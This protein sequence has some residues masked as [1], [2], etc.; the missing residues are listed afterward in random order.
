MSIYDGSVDQQVTGTEG[1]RMLSTPTSDNSYND[2]LSNLWTQGISTGADATNGEA[3]VKIYDGS[4]FNAV[5]DLTST[6]TPG[7]G[8]ITYVFDDDDN[9]GISDGF[10]KTI[11]VTGTENTGSITPLLNSGSDAWSL[12]G[13]P[14]AF[15]IDWD[16]VSKNDLTETLYVYDHS[17]TSYLTWNGSSGSLTGGVIASMQGFWV[18]NLDVD[19]AP[20]PNLTFEESDQ[21]SEGIFYKEDASNI[22]IELNAALNDLNSQTFL[23]FTESGELAKDN[24]DGLKLSPLDFKNYLSIATV[25]EDTKLDINNLP[26]DFEGEIK[27]PVSIQAFHADKESNEWISKKGEIFL[28]WSGMQNTP[29]DWSITLTDYATGQSVDMKTADS[30]SFTLLD[31]A[32]AKAPPSSTILNPHPPTVERLRKGINGTRMGVTIIRGKATGNEPNQTPEDFTLEQN[33]PNP[34][35]PTTSIEYTVGEAGPVS[36]SV[37]NVMGQKVATLVSET[38]VT[39]TYRV[40]WNAA[41]M[42]SGIYHYRLQS[43]G[44]VITKQMTLIK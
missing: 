6:M 29:A 17:S 31:E 24:Y 44:Q 26:V 13:N 42:A 23:S 3:N 4:V 40:N 9:D 10:P 20:S 38:K 15:S 1:W 36:L 25:A 11:S 18:Q 39:G 16:E 28:S 5:N 27:I 35:N 34:F 43:A 30:Y 37:Y 2:L 8:F 41:N 33:Y 32:Q 7:K 22:E 14:Y 21:V 12:V 19:P